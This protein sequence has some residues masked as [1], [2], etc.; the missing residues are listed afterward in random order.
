MESEEKSSSY[1]YSIKTC[2]SIQTDKAEKFISFRVNKLFIELL[3]SCC[4]IVHFG[5]SHPVSKPFVL[6]VVVVQ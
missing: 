1:I 3:R 4:L 5:N 2:I 6:F